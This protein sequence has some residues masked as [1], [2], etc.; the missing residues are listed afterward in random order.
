MT[1]AQRIFMLGLSGLGGYALGRKY[2]GRLIALQHPATTPVRY[3]T[4]PPRAPAKPLPWTPL[5]PTEIKAFIYRLPNETAFR[6]A[7][8]PFPSS[9]REMGLFDTVAMAQQVAREH[10]WGLA[11]EGA[12]D[13]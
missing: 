13:L 11:W 2:G 12:K 8:G 3:K 5:P 4:L 10:G 1:P 6:M 7:T 9:A